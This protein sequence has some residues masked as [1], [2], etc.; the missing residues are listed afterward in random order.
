MVPLCSYPGCPRQSRNTSAGAPRRG[1]GPHPLPGGACL[2][3]PGPRPV[4]T[5]VARSPPLAVLGTAALGSCGVA[6]PG[7]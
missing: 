5:A 2:S 7:A 6:S 1:G 4:H 3:R